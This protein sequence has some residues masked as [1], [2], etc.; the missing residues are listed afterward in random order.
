MPV[1]ER[2]FILTPTPTDRT[3][4]GFENKPLPVYQDASGLD[5]RWSSKMPLPKI[6]DRIYM[7]IN[8]I[9]YGEVKGY[10]VAE[11]D[12][13]AYLGLLVLPENPPD[14]Y[15]RQVGDRVKEHAMAQRLGPEKAKLERVREQPKWIREGI[16][17]VFGAEISLEK[18][19]VRCDM[20]V[21]G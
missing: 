11:T 15:K 21:V 7:R 14:W 16:A 2:F 18:D 3:L 1:V 20:K 12:N 13:G 5:M 4:P 10:F 6:G 17:A 9:G 19:E 8:S